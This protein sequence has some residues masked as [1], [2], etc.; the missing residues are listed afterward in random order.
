MDSL[1]LEVFTNPHKVAALTP[2]DW[3][4]LITRGREQNML[5]RLYAAVE[6]TNDAI[7]INAIAPTYVKHA[8][9]NLIVQARQRINIT[10][11]LIEI[12]EAFAEK[13]IT[14][15]I[16]KGAAYSLLELPVAHGRVFSDIDILVKEQDIP[17]A[18]LA[19]MTLGFFHSVE[20][21][22]DKRYYREWMHEIQPMVH[23]VRHTSIDLHH[24]ILPKTNDRHFSSSR[25][26]TQA[27]N[28]SNLNV[29]TPIDRFIHSA[30][31]LFT[32]G[33]FPHA[34][35]DITDLMLL[36][37]DINESDS[38]NLLSARAAELGLSSYLALA[39]YFVVGDHTK[40]LQ[41]YYESEASVPWYTTKLTLPAYNIVFNSDASLGTSVKHR[42]AL[43]WLYAR[44]HII[45]MPLT[46]LVPHLIKKFI[47]NTKE[48]LKDEPEQ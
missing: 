47:F 6:R 1:L 22:Y 39:L 34:I 2:S 3:T 45:K 30:T 4:H 13:G 8:S 14:A 11:E 5:G 18:E 40:S 28:F 29:L 46:I 7:L 33:E 19:L 41:D 10:R 26:T 21:D 25:L 17:T 27:T 42:C 20:T 35:R 9:N 36:F 32:E 16:L 23:K 12:N 15:I 31:H 37:N 43:A 24:N 38:V 48:R 44:S